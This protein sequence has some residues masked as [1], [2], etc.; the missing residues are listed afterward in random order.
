M[1]TALL[2]L[3][4]RRAPAGYER[5]FIHGVQVIKPRARHPWVERLILAGWLLI[6]VKCF[7]VIWVINRWAVPFHPYWIIVP[8]IL[9]AALG[10]AIYYWRD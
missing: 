10:T 8:T 1:L 5:A 7:V 4:L 6:V 2:Q 3:V 9:M